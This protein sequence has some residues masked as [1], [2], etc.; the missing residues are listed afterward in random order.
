MLSVGP[1]ALRGDCEAAQE[2]VLVTLLEEAEQRGLRTGVVSTATIT[3][4]TP[5][6][7]YAHVAERGWEADVEVPEEYRETC[8]DIARQFVEFPYG[9]A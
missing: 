4:A 6:A 5:A 1:Q 7:T 2:H 9:D 8:A 3:H